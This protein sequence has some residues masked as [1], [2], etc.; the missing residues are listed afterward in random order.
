MTRPA[1]RSFSLYDRGQVRVF[2]ILPVGLVLVG[3]VLGVTVLPKDPFAAVVFLPLAFAAVWF[4]LLGLSIPHTIEWQNDGT[5]DFCSYRGRTKVTPREIES[6]QPKRGQAA[7]LVV[8]TSR[9]KIVLIN[10]F[11]GFHE[12]LVRL[13]TANPAVKLRGC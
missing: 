4:T 11:D 10:Q 12:F 5:I 3:I 1:P 2:L 9:K 8:Q 6:I 13:E 7:F